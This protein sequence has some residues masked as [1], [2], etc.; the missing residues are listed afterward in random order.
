MWIVVSGLLGICITA[1]VASLWPQFDKSELRATYAMELALEAIADK[2]RN[3]GNQRDELEALRALNLGAATARV[4]QYPGLVGTALI[5]K[6]RPVLQETPY[7]DRFLRR[8]FEDL[9]EMKAERLRL[10]V[11]S[12]VA[13]VGLAGA[14]YAIGWSIAW[15]RRGFRGA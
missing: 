5:E 13:W 11:Y 2:A 6:L 15:V 8:E 9:E 7:E 4:Q 12:F 1:V 14:S 3:A 10:I